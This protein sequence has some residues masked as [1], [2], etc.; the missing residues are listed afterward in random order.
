MKPREPSAALIARLQ[1]ESNRLHH[2]S[3]VY[4]GDFAQ[5]PWAEGAATG[6]VPYGTPGL[7]GV[8]DIADI[9]LLVRVEVNAL[10][11]MLVRKGVFTSEEWVRECI[12]QTQWFTAQ[13]EQKFNVKSTAEGLVLN[14]SA[15][16]EEKQPDGQHRR[17]GSA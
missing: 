2:L 11:N 16:E 3:M 13:K 8:R 15:S 7:K 1:A 6:I 14:P 10:V 5:L 9:A 17:G 12:E 4:A